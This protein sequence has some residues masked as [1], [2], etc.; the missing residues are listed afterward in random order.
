MLHVALL[1]DHP[2]VLAGL[3]RLVEPEPDLVI[4]GAAPDAPELARQ[5]GDLRPDVLVL[6]DDLAGSDGLSHCRRITDRPH[7]PAVV[8]YSAD[9]SAALALAARAAHADA[10]VDKAEPVSALLSAIR[11]VVAGETVLPEISRDAYE[12]A[13]S[14]L[15]DEDLPVLAMLLEGESLPAIAETMRTDPAEIARR[16]QRIVGRL[17]PRA[18]TRL[19]EPA[20]DRRLLGAP[21]RWVR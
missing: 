3:R 12:A 14:R 17:R 21:P 11:A 19:D 15:A 1:D 5:L 16:A 20:G 18:G 10:I 2:A 4:V 13:V 8:L 9:A 6:D 7:P